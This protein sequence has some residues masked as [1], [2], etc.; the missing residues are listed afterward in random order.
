[1]EQKSFADLALSPEMLHAV[2]D[3][4]YEEATPIQAESI[5]H[6]LEGQD[7]LGQAQT[8]TGKTCAF[9]IPIIERVDLE[10]EHIQYLVLS[11]TR[12]LAIQIADALHELTK[13]KEGIRVL[14]V[15]GGQP[16]DRQ[17]LALKKRPQI[18][19]GT[20]GRVMDHM[21][22]KTIRLDNLRGI[23]LDE[24]DEM[25]NMGFKED[26][27]TILAETP[28]R[29]QRIFFS[30][31]MPKGIL[32]LTEKYLVNPIQVRMLMRQM[33]V[34][35]IEQY[36]IEVRES[37]K[38]EVLCRLIEADRIKLALIFCNMKRRVDEVCEKLQTRGYSA[39]AL[40]GD[41]KQ[42]ARTRVMNRFKNGDVEILVATDVAA[43]GIDVDNIEVVINYDLPQDEEYYVH[44]IGRTARAG[45]SGKAYTFVVGREILDL[46]NIQHF[47]HSSISRSQPPTLLNV[48]EGRVSAILTEAGAVMAGGGL[49]TFLS[50]AEQYLEQLNATSEDDTYYTTADLAAALLK[51]AMGQTLL[52]AGEIEPVVPYEEMI[53]RR[54]QAQGAPSQ[55]YGSNGPSDAFRSALMTQPGTSDEPGAAD[56]QSER[57]HGVKRNK[58]VEDGMTRLFIN[59]GAED[60]VLPRVIVDAIH[61]YA[62]LDRKQIGSIA[63]YGRFTFVDV[64]NEAAQQVIEGLSH[65]QI[66]KREVRVERGDRS[67]GEK[68]WPDRTD[69][70]KRNDRREHSDHR[71]HGGSAKTWDKKPDIKPK[72]DDKRADAKP[73]YDDKR[74]DAK[75]GDPVVRKYDKDTARKYDKDTARKFDKGDG[76]KFDKG[77]GKKFA[78][79]DG[80]KFDKGDGRK[81][82]K[83]AAKKYDKGTAKKTDKSVTKK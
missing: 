45:R 77:D 26:I 27:D 8:G 61:D 74:A 67:G 73:K 70:P 66:G 39:E 69:R 19:V 1:M 23:V 46:K 72:H 2:Q 17:I 57:M 15:Y 28:G 16:I 65:Q 79:G 71:D 10:D 14:C 25:L 62:R 38:I 40:H 48:T 41:M 7:I 49:D 63:V 20:P 24:A 54:R 55:R 59:V 6:I 31:T 18:I 36:Y 80:K 47:T 32:E 83:G 82:D 44:R 37:S 13:Y 64:P 50:A 53:N 9:G 75:S 76:K 51:Q 43:R 78:K 12:E 52:Q 4:G 42:M 33:T 30:A 29:I 22:R 68:A 5:P 58:K 60:H 81:F 21:R 34:S 35:N 3:M 56:G 11:P